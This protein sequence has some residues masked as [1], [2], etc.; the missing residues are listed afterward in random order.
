MSRGRYVVIVAALFSALWLIQPSAQDYYR[1]NTTTP[2]GTGGATAFIGGTLFTS[3]TA[4]STT[5]LVEETLMS[6]PMPGGT[7]AVDGRG[8]RITAKGIYAANAN[9]KAARLYFGAMTAQ[10][11]GVFNGT[12]FTLELIVGRRSATTQM[13]FFTGVSSGGVQIPTN[14]LTGTETLSGS[15]L[16]KLTGTGATT[17]GDITATLLLVEAI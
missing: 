9:T 16:I 10:T 17:I 14:P 4:T 15:V 6:Y 13:G 12:G 2:V 7:L 3:T 8:L 5:G 11:V 1:G